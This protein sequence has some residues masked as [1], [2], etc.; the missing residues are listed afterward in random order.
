MVEKNSLAKD[1]M[2]RAMRGFASRSE[3]PL[4]TLLGPAAREQP[5]VMART[6]EQ[7]ATSRIICVRFRDDDR[8][9]VRWEAGWRVARVLPKFWAAAQAAR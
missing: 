2:I 7:V 4:D 3:F 1:F 9:Q 8:V 5:I 6:S